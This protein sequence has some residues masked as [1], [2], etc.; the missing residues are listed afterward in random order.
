[1]FVCEFVNLHVFMFVWTQTC[2]SLWLCMFAHLSV[3]VLWQKCSDY[4]CVCV[5]VCVCVWLLSVVQ[6]P[7]CGLW[8]FITEPLQQRLHGTGG[9]FYLLMHKTQSLSHTHIH[10]HTHPYL[11]TSQ[12]WKH[13]SSCMADRPERRRRCVVRWWETNHPNTF[14]S[15]TSRTIESPHVTAANHSCAGTPLV[16]KTH[17]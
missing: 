11:L 15:D 16:K 9:M 12:E 1:M 7:D 2:V 8:I 5:C 14:L 10:T 17:L 4:Q 3:T 13:P 6:M